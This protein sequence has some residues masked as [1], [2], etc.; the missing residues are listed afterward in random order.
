MVLAVLLLLLGNAA[1]SSVS[2]CKLGLPKAKYSSACRL[3]FSIGAKDKDSDREVP[4]KSVLATSEPL[5][6]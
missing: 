2:A 6:S 4:L 1:S 5:R 3:G